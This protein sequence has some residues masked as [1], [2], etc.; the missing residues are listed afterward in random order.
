M[1]S[2]NCALWS[3]VAYVNNECYHI[4]L[5]ETRENW[6]WKHPKF[7]PS[8]HNHFIQLQCQ[9]IFQ[10]PLQCLT[11]QNLYLTF[12]IKKKQQNTWHLQLIVQ[13]IM[14]RRMINAD[15]SSSKSNS[16]IS[17]M[18]L[19]YQHACS[20]LHLQILSHLS[21]QEVFCSSFSRRNHSFS[22][23]QTVQLGKKSNHSKQKVPIQIIELWLYQ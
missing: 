17:L 23:S 1:S 14:I 9:I 21:N 6:I 2:R 19:W 8:S 22:C 3:R 13:N 4:S 15:L 10:L 5:I 7:T 11:S 12:K 20:H 18:V 16:S